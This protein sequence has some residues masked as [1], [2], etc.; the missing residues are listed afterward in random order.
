MSILSL[1]LG[2]DSQNFLCKFVRFLKLQA[3]KSWGLKYSLKQI[4]LKGYVNNCINHKVPIK[5]TLKLQKELRICLKSFVNSQSFWIFLLKQ[6]TKKQF[7]IFR[8]SLGV[9][10]RIWVQVSRA[11]SVARSKAWP[12]WHKTFAMSWYLFRAGTKGQP[13]KKLNHLEQS[14]I[15]NR[16]NYTVS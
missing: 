5:S 6:K 11:W 15:N 13:L 3:L 1:S 14:R 9:C 4:S 16:A 2:G 10:S 7:G 8:Q 12:S